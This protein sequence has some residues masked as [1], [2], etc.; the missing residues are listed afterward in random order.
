MSATLSGKPGKLYLTWLFI[1]TRS[2]STIFESGRGPCRVTSDSK[3]PV[4]PFVSWS[5]MSKFFVI[6]TRAPRTRSSL[7]GSSSVSRVGRFK[8]V[9]FI[10]ALTSF[11]TYVSSA[12]SVKTSRPV[13]FDKSVTRKLFIL[14]FTPF[15]EHTTGASRHIASL[16][17]GPSLEPSI[18]LLIRATSSA[19]QLPSLTRLRNSANGRS[20]LCLTCCTRKTTRLTWCHKFRPF[21]SPML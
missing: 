20:S 12:M 3:V 5:E 10:C 17:L 9:C 1:F 18:R 13:R 2:H 6:I 19:V 8:I 7:P 21:I 16:V 14:S 4:A 15:R 11:V